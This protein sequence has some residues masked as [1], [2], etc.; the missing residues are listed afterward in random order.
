MRLSRFL[1]ILVF[2]FTLLPNIGY[3]DSPKARILLVE[4]AHFCPG[5]VECTNSQLER[6]YAWAI[7]GNNYSFDKCVVSSTAGDGPGYNT[8]TASCSSLM[9][10]Y[11]IVIWFTAFDIGTGSDLNYPTLTATDRQNLKWYLDNG[12]KVFLTGQNIAFDVGY[13]TLLQDYFDATFAI[14]DAG[15]NR[16]YDALSG[17]DPVADGFNL[18][19]AD[20]SLIDNP[21]TIWRV[22]DVSY[23]VFFYNALCTHPTQGTGYC[24]AGLRRQT[25]VYKNVFF[26]F[27]FERIISSYIYGKST[28]ANITRT[29]LMKEILGY[30]APP[31]SKGAR[32]TPA[33]TNSTIVL[34]VTCNTTQ[35]YSKITAA[36]Y[37]ADTIGSFGSGAALGARDGSFNSATEV[38]N[39]TINTAG[40]SEGNHTIAVHCKDFDGFWG[41]FDNATVTVDRTAPTT[42]RIT[43]ESDS[44]PG[45]TYTNK[46]KPTLY[47]AD[48]NASDGNPDYMR[49]SCDNSNWADWIA[50]ATIYSAFNITNPSYGCLNSDGPKAAYVQVKDA[51]GNVQTTTLS[52]NITLDRQPPY[53]ASISKANN[54]FITSSAGLTIVLNDSLSGAASTGNT[55][56]NGNG[57]RTGFSSGMAFNPGYT[58]EGNKTLNVSFIDNAGNQNW[59]LYSFAIDNTAPAFSLMDPANG[60]YMNFARNIR[61]DVTESFSG[62]SSSW[63]D[64]GNGTNTSFSDNVS[65]N[66][67]YSAEGSRTL[68]VYANDSAGNMNTTL[69][70]FIAD[71]TSPAFSSF[72]PA[73]S[74]NITAS[75][76]VTISFSDAVSGANA[77]ANNGNGTNSSITSNVSFSPGFTGE[78]PRNL[79]IYLNDSAGNVNNALLLYTL[80]VTPPNTT[81]N[82]TFTDW[83]TSDQPVRLNCTDN[84]TACSVTLYCTHRTTQ[85]ECIPAT[86]GTVATAACGLDEECQI[87][88]RYRSNDSVGNT[89]STKNSS[90]V[91]IDKKAP[92][93]TILNP[94][95]GSSRSGTIEIRANITDLGAG[96]TNATYSI[97]NASNT[98]QAISGGNL[99]YPNWNSTF[100]SNPYT[101]ETFV[102]V[103]NSSDNANNSASRNATFTIDNQKPSA[104]I[105][106][107]KEKIVGG[108]FSLDMRGSA[109]TGRIL[110]ECSYYIYNSTLVANYSVAGISSTTCSFTNTINIQSLADGNYSANFTSIDNT[111]ASATDRSWVYMDRQK[112]SVSIISPSNASL[113]TGTINVS[114]SASDTV[115]LSSCSWSF[116]QSG[117]N[118]PFNTSCTANI[119]FSTQLCSDNNASNCMIEVSATDEAGNSNASMI[120]LSI[121]NSPPSVSIASPSANSWQSNSFNASFS[122]ADTSNLSCMFRIMGSSDSGWMTM[123]CVQPFLA[124]ISYCQT[125]GMARCMITVQANDSV[126]LAA[127]AG[128]NFSVDITRPSFVYISPAN[129][130]RITS[131]TQFTV[132]VSDSVSGVASLRF[133]N[134]NGTN[135]SLSSGISFSPAFSGNGQRNITLYATDSAGNTNSTYAVYT[136]D[137]APPALSNISFN[138]TDA[139][140]G[141]AR[142]HPF[143]S[144][145]IMANLSDAGGISYAFVELNYSGMRR[146]YSLSPDSGEANYSL[147]FANTNATGRYAITML[148]ANDS[149]G[150]AASLNET[151]LNRSFLV[152]NSTLSATINGSKT[153]DSSTN[154]SVLL[155]INFNRSMANRSFSLF[156]PDSHSN[157]SQ[158]ECGSACSMV[159]SGNMITITPLTDVSSVN[160]TANI[161]ASAKVQDTNFS[162]TIGTG[163]TNI[164]DYTATISPLLNITS[165]LCDGLSACIFNQSSYFNLTIIARN[166]AGNGRSGKAYSVNLSF[167]SDA[168]NNYT[169]IESMP[170]NSSRAASW[171]ISLPV[172]GIFNFTATAMDGLSGIFNA[173]NSVIVTALDTERPELS[174][175]DM[176]VNI[177]NINESTS[178]TLAASDNVNVTAAWAMVNDSY[179]NLTNMSLSLLT[180]SIQSGTWELVF[181]QTQDSRNYTILAEYANDSQGNTGSLNTTIQLEVKELQFNASLSNATLPV[182]NTLTIQTNISE[183]ASAVQSVQALIMKPGNVTETVSLSRVSGGNMS[184]SGTYGNITRSGNYTVSVTVAMRITA[185]RNLTFSVPLGNISIEPADGDGGQVSIPLGQPVNIS[186]LLTPS[187]GDLVNISAYTAASGVINLTENF[188]SIGNVTF[189]GVRPRKISF[190]VNGTSA[191]QAYVNFTV[192]SSYHQP[193]NRSILISVIAGDTQKPQI[194][195][196]SK[197]YST[198]NLYETNTISANVTDNSIINSVTVQVTH[199]SGVKQNHSATQVRNNIYSLDFTNANE[200]G[201]FSLIVFA[202]DISGNINSSSGGS[203]NVTDEYA[204]TVLTPYISYNKGENVSVNVI[205]K[206]ANNENVTGFN[207]SL[208]LDKAEA[209]A[210]LA[211]GSVQGSAYYRIEATDKPDAESGS[212]ATYVVYAN[213]SKNGN[214]GAATSAFGVYKSLTTQIITPAANEFVS[215]AQPLNMRVRVLNVRSEPV[216]DASVIVQCQTSKCN[217][218]FALLSKESDGIYTNN[219]SLSAA[220][221]SGPFSIFASGIDSFKNSGTDFVVPTTQQSSSSGSSGASAGGGTS[222]SAGAA[223]KNLSREGEACA[224]DRDCE[225]GLECDMMLLMCR[226]I[227]REAEKVAAFDLLLY[228]LSFEIRQGMDAFISGKIRNTGNERLDVEVGVQSEC[229]RFF[230]EKGSLQIEGIKGTEKSLQIKIHVPLTARPSDYVA[231]LT[232]ADKD[233]Q[234]EKTA[235]I[236][237]KVLPNRLAEAI[238]NKYPKALA[239]L[240]NATEELEN[241]GIDVESL[242]GKIDRIEKALEEAEKAISSDDLQSLEKLMS[243]TE[244]EFIQASLESVGLAFLKFVY[245]N[246][247]AIVAVIVVV[248]FGSYFVTAF[249]IP[250]TRLRRNL[251]RLL[252]EE[253]AIV[254]SRK[255]AE[256]QYFK[257]KID[258]KT[259]RSIMVKEQ[260]RLLTARAKET[261]AR[262]EMSR[263]FGATFSFKPLLRQPKAGQAKDVKP[264]K[265][266]ASD[267]Q[268]DGT[269]G[270]TLGKKAGKRSG[271]ESIKKTGGISEAIE[272]M[273]RGAGRGKE[274]KQDDVARDIRNRLSKIESAMPKIYGVERNEVEEEYRLAKDFAIKGLDLMASYHLE[275]CEEI[276]KR[277]EK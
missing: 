172:A 252:A 121:D 73:N 200:T 270:E 19:I 84:V 141:D 209:N 163:E 79:T 254:A 45:P 240:K 92:S 259:F 82:Y 166:E 269:G 244:D 11:D 56:D 201:N 148:F 129:G 190:A 17:Q 260:D 264:A 229:C 136:L 44:E 118:G 26:S 156:L 135:T 232:V 104:A 99:T 183:N 223:A 202:S 75:T 46:E 158:Y 90:L 119:S 255:S 107:P 57:T 117:T 10:N 217:N 36:E 219:Q 37:F 204:V 61:I 115:R 143:E 207:L 97:L 188:R 40:L 20:V 271:T 225:G 47:I 221:A 81:D 130:S 91:R 35:R 212:N 43:I 7:Q 112:P 211:D 276:L 257:R 98:S 191:G 208:I 39:V 127:S 123:P 175:A 206:N 96:V 131:S 55:F 250:Y 105:F 9:K 33:L 235:S 266:A 27:A 54:S 198:L 74:S 150:N 147:A 142:V 263:L 134:G 195:S 186:V 218:Q 180:G 52:D 273:L 120:Y 80:D 70:V 171:N 63:F 32:L 29:M 68:R 59:T 66:P 178:I 153:I 170:S 62:I 236:F 237:I 160:V 194:N 154:G 214:R 50:W 116:S 83:K 72:S 251:Q 145:R 227:Q 149:L 248:S 106:F 169:V 86:A 49:F 13:T 203:F 53:I 184:Y 267:S 138:V 28:S 139:I 247:N 185:T 30:L 38:A 109:V 41:K 187:N 265:D 256:I 228:Q 25:S 192:N 2:A 108:N 58:S 22:R 213:A 21:D 174:S 275:R 161:S 128:R 277:L 6:Y 42:S 197:A 274:S 137:N 3:S 69:F 159:Y 222:G 95:H 234:A 155:F 215:T 162:W 64:N 241:L 230:P 93:I 258:E 78:G 157:I 88:V 31:D 5:G 124:N 60:S 181:N 167:S 165:M 103:V 168:G 1:L 220:D 4:D 249:A 176:P 77:L 246:I 18:R 8:T 34:N 76:A 179:G 182:N 261:E 65:F 210:T 199:P 125:E 114:F 253:Q 113:R 24:R 71:N 173:S 242:K 48:Q 193:A 16:V 245:S 100:N 177:V 14:G 164:S 152:V 102:L 51:A 89:E 224:S 110:T 238:R 205:V 132:A 226:K 67:G 231:V 140:F 239:E 85:A 101:I 272:K 146:N 122:A 23:L 196:V 189:E 268:K 151:Q 243:A 15:T 144:I 262:Q 12:G 94:P 111:T 216:A 87:Y 126:G 233:G 133:D